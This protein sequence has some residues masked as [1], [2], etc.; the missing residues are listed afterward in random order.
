M[1]MPNFKDVLQKLSVL[2]NNLSLLASIIIAVVGLL[3]FIPTQ[4][5][6]SKLKAQIEA[7]SVRMGRQIGRMDPVSRQQRE[8]EKVYQ[9]AH[10]KDANEIANLARQSTQREVLSYGI[11]PEP[12]TSSTLLFEQFGKRFRSGVD[13]MI[14][15]V[16]GLDRPSD[17]EL[18]K[19]LQ[20]AT[21]GTGAR[22]GRSMI[23]APSRLLY[24]S[25]GARGGVNA[26][27]LEQVCMER[28]RTARV[29]A[30][31]ADVGGYAFWTEYKFDT[32]VDESV[33]EC[34]YWQLGYWIIEDVIA[35]IG[36]CNSES[37]SVLEAPVKR[38]LGVDFALKRRGMASRSLGRRGAKRKK[39]DVKPAYVLSAKDG[40]TVPCTG[41]YTNEED[42]IDV[43]HFSTIAVVR[44][45]AVLKFTE[46]LCSAKEH[47]FRGLSGTEPEQT[48]QHN[49]ITVLESDVRA[50][51]EGPSHDYYRYGDDA[52][53]ELDLICE[54]IF[55]REGYKDSIPKVV[56]DEV[57]LLKQDTGPRRR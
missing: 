50:V 56:T 39:D 40:L 1:N 38:L 52:V 36:A 3:L 24:R 46:E 10:V 25:L 18:Q 7:E 28:A 43:V 29:Y 9:D 13:A 2:K 33:K 30:N 55:N 32:G 42:N 44:A 35:T 19:S 16:N 17:S 34:W 26:E 12:Q 37:D 6:S 51:E 22:R 49:Q 27:V 20:N 41:R 21:A 54:Y 23:G 15:N 11:F 14:S 47:K 53:V 57:E 45:D 4:L 31:P 8:V 5:M 48:F